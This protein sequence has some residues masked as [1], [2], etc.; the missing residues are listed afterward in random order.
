MGVTGRP[1]EFEPGFSR[2]SCRGVDEESLLEQN[3]GTQ[4]ST[5]APKRL[6]LLMIAHTAEVGNAP[7]LDSLLDS[8][9]AFVHQ[10][11]RDA[12]PAHHVERQLFARVLA[13][14]REAFALFLS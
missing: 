3:V 9:V 2:A 10:A 14:G 7:A 11:A 5:L 12:S 4:Q 6:T 1:R 8:L 13:L